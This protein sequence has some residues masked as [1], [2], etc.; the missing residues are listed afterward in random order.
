MP[1]PYPLSRLGATIDLNGISAPTFEDI[2]QSFQA[3]YRQIYGSDV[4]LDPDTQDGQWLAVQSQIVYDTNAAV[5]AAYLSYS[6][7]WAQGIGLSSEVKING[8]R[9]LVPSNSAV[10]VRLVGQAGTT[11]NNGVIA[12]D[13]QNRWDLP[14]T[15]IIPPQ[16]EITVTAIAEVAG[17]LTAGANSVTTMVTMVPGWQSVSNPAPATPGAPLES[18][19]T[20]RKRQS[21]S[22]AIAAISPREAIRAALLNLEG[23]QRCQVWDNDTDSVDANGIPAHSIAV[24]IEGG[25]DTL[26]A[27]TIFIKKNTGCGTYGTTKVI[28]TDTTGLPQTINFWRMQQYP[29]YVGITIRPLIGYQDSTGSLLINCVV[30]YINQLDIGATV[31]TEWL[32]PPANLSGDVATG[33]S[34]MTQQQL[35]ILSSTYVV[36]SIFIGT[37][38]APTSAAEIPV[39]FT[40]AATCATAWVTLTVTPL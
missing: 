1:G 6:P 29:I 24:V 36:E 7:T 19:A 34:A 27:S 31:H 5:I 17:A 8:L 15:V 32:H 9:R 20:L 13:F 10:D 40:A 11:I 3:A 2:F 25:D 16:G 21:V 26:I 22:T 18:D 33:F 12:D 28:I 38:P 35:D 23:V 30:S 39:P 14:A 4:D 37:N